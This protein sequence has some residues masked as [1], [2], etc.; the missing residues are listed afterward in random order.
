MFRARTGSVETVL[1]LVAIVPSAPLLVPELAGPAA[2][3][4]EP[5][6][7]AVRAVAKRLGSAADRWIALGA[8]DRAG[9]AG[10]T[11]Y[12]SC[13]DFGG[14]G[15]PHPVRL[16]GPPTEGA[17]LPLSM[18]I[19]G[20]VR[21]EADGGGE[22]TTVTPWVVDPEW[23]P[24][25]CA[26]AGLE[27][28]RAL[29]DGGDPDSDDPDSG[30]PDSGDRVG[31]LVVA[32]GCTALSPGA[33]GGGERPSA[34]ALQRR[35]DDALARADTGALA[36]LDADA[37]AA[38]GVGGRAA[39]QVLAAACGG[40]AADV[41]VSDVAAAEVL[42]RDAPFGVGYTVAVWSPGAPR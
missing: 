29:S 3:D 4:T 32:D 40:P 35:I 25:Q 8:A 22:R 10:A 11:D 7:A 6:R 26:A 17:P 27:L 15:V 9:S 20:W 34:I 19:A 42:Y 33:P 18:L 14:Y 39:W 38:E 21:G 30:D 13:G 12:R 2:T 16:G 23:S 37:C 41:A 1:A 24:D 28:A 36:A 5:V 31:L